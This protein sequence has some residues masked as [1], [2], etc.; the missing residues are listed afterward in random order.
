[1][2]QRLTG[3]GVRLLGASDHTITHSLYIED[4]E[5]DEIELYIDPA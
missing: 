4:P 1:M 5:G 2:R 3:A